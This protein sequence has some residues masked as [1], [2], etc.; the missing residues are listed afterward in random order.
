[1]MSYLTVKELTQ[2]RNLWR[3]LSAERESVITRGP[4]PGPAL[5][6]HTCR[7]AL[8]ISRMPR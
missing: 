6:F 3:Q 1:M 7:Q 8:H 5:K 4:A 2:T